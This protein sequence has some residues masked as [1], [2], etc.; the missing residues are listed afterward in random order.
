MKTLEEEANQYGADDINDDIYFSF[1]AGAKS[2]WVQ[3]EIIKAQL[4][5]L[6]SFYY[7]NDLKDED[8]M[9]FYTELHSELTD[10]LTQKLKTLEDDKG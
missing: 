10:E 6:N 4:D 3:A 5:I 9:R 7:G 1:I 8:I 2:K